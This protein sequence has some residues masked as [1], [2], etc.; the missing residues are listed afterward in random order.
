MQGIS[1][2]DGELLDSQEGVRPVELHVKRKRKFILIL[3]LEYY[4]WKESN[5]CT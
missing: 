2:V 5:F 1:W 3:Y 4:V